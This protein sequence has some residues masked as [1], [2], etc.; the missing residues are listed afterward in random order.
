MLGLLEQQALDPDSPLT[1]DPQWL[2]GTR[3]NDELAA[4][5]VAPK[6]D[7]AARIAKRPYRGRELGAARNADGRGAGVGGQGDQ[8]PEQGEDDECT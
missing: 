5:V 1:N 2:R 6:L 8:E 4:V 3:T 7:G